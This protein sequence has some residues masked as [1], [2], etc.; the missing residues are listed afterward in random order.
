MTLSDFL[1]ARFDEVE[2]F[3]FYRDLFPAGELERQG[4]FV[5]GKYCGIAIEIV[6]NKKAK[7]YSLTD[8]LSLIDKLRKSK[9]FCVISPVSYA[10]KSQ[11]QENARFMY[12]IVFDV[13]GI[14]FDGAD[15]VGLRSI[16]H[17]IEDGT[18]LE[19]G[20]SFL[21]RPTYIVSSGTGLHLYYL[22][23]R[24][25]PLF[26]N[27]IKQLAAYRRALTKRIWNMYVTTLSENVQYESVTQGFR[28]VGTVTKDGKARARAFKVGERVS[29]EYM[30]SFVESEA[31]VKEYSYK[32]NLT[33][34]EAKKKYPDWYENRVV[35]GKPAGAW[36][37]NRALYDWWIRQIK[38]KAVLGHRYFCVMAMAIFAR[39]CDISREELEADA[40]SLVEALNGLSPADRSNDFSEDDVVKALEAFNASYQTFPR[41]NIEQITAIAIP[42]NK[43]NYRRRETHLALVNSLRRLRR[44][45]L[46]EDEY[47]KSG[48]PTKEFRVR[49]YAKE[50]PDANNAQIA[51]AA[52]VSRQTVIKYLKDDE[53]RQNRTF[54][55][56]T[57]QV[58]VQTYIKEHPTATDR[59]ISKAL[60]IAMST[61]LKWR[62]DL[63]K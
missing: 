40:F 50:H 5:T 9:N 15:P 53:S 25:I 54:G 62:R 22:L 42:A 27:V 29:M 47:A 51:R 57:K 56:P 49:S 20:G 59:E 38:T 4:E 17:Q 28:M 19:N 43:R 37:A 48:R 14:R 8:E 11:K 34:E 41:K 52:K 61:V 55:K 23:E 39:K 60:R 35:K 10:G 2:P 16:L 30:N 3:D 24:P 58:E 31:Q 12:A 32:S 1:S 13:D 63:E 7:R 36:I 6:S 46:G 33:L 45:E 26:R 44:D 18:S 21:P